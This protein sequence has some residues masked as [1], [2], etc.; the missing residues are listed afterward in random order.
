M[1]TNTGDGLQVADGGLDAATWRDHCKV[2]W[3]QQL[4]EHGC[5]VACLAMVSKEPYA[6]VRNLFEQAGLGQQRGRKRPFASNFREVMDIAERL[7]LRARMRRWQGWQAM[8][9][10]GIIKV[11]AKAPNWH[12]M[13]VERTAGFGVVAL[14]PA[15]DWPAFDHAPLDV[16][17]RSPS[18]LQP[19]GN[20][21]A[22]QVSAAA[23]L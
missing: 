22:I 6:V 9:G 8:D 17:Y 7:G 5:G 21:I 19:C 14:D 11:P 15:I 10:V 20:W 18:L 12:W 23:S 1:L 3:T 4:D 2:R 16:V 13:V